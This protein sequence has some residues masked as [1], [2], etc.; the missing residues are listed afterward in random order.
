[1]VADEPAIT[2]AWEE[3]DAY[4]E[5]MLAQRRS[6]LT[7]DLVSD[8]IFPTTTATVLGTTSCSCW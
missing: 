4:L 5:E 6:H 7:D 8:L 1:V 2:A 3:L